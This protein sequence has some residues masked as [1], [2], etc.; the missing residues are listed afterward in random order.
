MKTGILLCHDFDATQR[1]QSY[2][3]CHYIILV[4][5]LDVHLAPWEMLWNNL[6]ILTCLCGIHEINFMGR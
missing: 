5:S 3:Y 1:T 6:E 2:Y 4:R